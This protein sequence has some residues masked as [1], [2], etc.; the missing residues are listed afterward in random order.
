MTTDLA[1]SFLGSGAPP[2]SLRRA[3]PAHLVEAGGSKV[4]IDCG[5]GVSQRLIAAGHAGAQIDALI[6]THEHS[7]H[8]VDFYQLIVSSWHQGRNRPWR[9]LAPAPALA[10]MRG[11]YEAF[12]RERALR[13]AFEKRPDATGLEV[14][15]EELRE[16]PVAGMEGLGIEAFLVDHKPV[17]PAFGL[18]L[19]ANGSR[20][21]F[22]GDTRL[23]PSLERAAQ[24][25]DLL[26]CEVF[27]DS[28]MPVTA[29]VRSAETVASVQSY[30]MTPAVVAGLAKR[31]D[32]KALALT[33]LVPPG[34]DTV[35][36]FAEVRAGGYTGPL[37][38]GEDL[39]RLELPARLLRW[40]GAALGF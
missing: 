3:G 5:S 8:L 6:V 12:A 18:S 35:A 1:F 38:V 16:G 20:V 9:V 15:F 24:G 23:T 36:L 2:V 39:M 4:L 7:D 10:N 26:V 40:N 25:C 30:H 21:V 37:I 11:Q 13:I 33:H 14:V 34:A 28:Q 32:V 19:S 29:G 17:E 27:I 22:S 31:A